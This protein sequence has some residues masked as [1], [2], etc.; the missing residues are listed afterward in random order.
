MWLVINNLEMR[1]EK[2]ELLETSGLRCPKPFPDH[3]CLPVYRYL[4]YNN[5]PREGRNVD[6]WQPRVQLKRE[7]GSSRLVLSDSESVAAFSDKFIVKPKFV[8]EY[9]THLDMVDLKKKKR[10]E[11]REKESQKAKEK[12]YEDYAWKD[13]C[14]D[15]TKLKKLPELN[16]YLKHHRL[17]KYLKSTKSDKVKVI[18][19]HW[20]LQMNPEGTDLLQTR[21][22]ERDEAENEPLLDRDNDGSGQDD[23]VGSRSS[24]DEE[25]ENDYIDSGDRDESSDVINIFAF[26]DDEEVERPATTRSGRAITR[27]SKIDFSFY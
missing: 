24:S 7:H 12:N 1:K 22:G 6:D 3:S 10:A 9:L 18:T 23:N 4:S 15:P 13:L 16:K 21:M 11:K 19:R 5:T 26:I 14:E 17:E 25:N 2:Q 27:R 8:V 20:L